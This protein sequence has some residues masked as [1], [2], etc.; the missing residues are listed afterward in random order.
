VKVRVLLLLIVWPALAGFCDGLTTD[1]RQGGYLAGKCALGNGAYERRLRTREDTLQRLDRSEQALD[2]RLRQATRARADLDRDL[3]ATRG[4]IE[5]DRRAIAA[6]GAE[7]DRR[8]QRRTASE[9]ELAALKAEKTA[10]EAQFAE[11]YE[12]AAATEL[13]VRRWR[14]R[15][16][17]PEVAGGMR[18][19]TREA[20]LAETRMRGRIDGLRRRMESLGGGAH[21]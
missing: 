14:D 3:A 8:R 6:L 5:A 10:I 18:E 15:G 2:A 7:L 19:R 20:E 9:A 13:A 1:P 17:E 4:R 21:P 12:A 11:L 16:A